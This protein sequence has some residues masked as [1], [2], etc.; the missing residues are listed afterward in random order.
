MASK[1]DDW[2]ISGHPLFCWQGFQ[3]QLG[4]V[5]MRKWGNLHQDT[6]KTW[7]GRGPRV[8]GG[9][10]HCTHASSFLSTCVSS[11]SNNSL[12]D[13]GSLHCGWAPVCPWSQ[14]WTASELD[15][16]IEKEENLHFCN[17]AKLC[18]LPI[19]FHKG[20]SWLVLPLVKALFT[21]TLFF[22]R[23]ISW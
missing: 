5:C 9:A 21:S 6:C 3:G 12:W 7:T 19:S 8:E 16:M 17:G 4:G 20:D 23:S 2:T 13:R 15:C 22:E 14:V 11:Q 18:W 1:Q 10:S